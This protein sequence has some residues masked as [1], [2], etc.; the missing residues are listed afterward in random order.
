MTAKDAI[1]PDE[2]HR[3][4]E[5]PE[6]SPEEHPEATRIAALLRERFGIER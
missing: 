1:A 4:A 5:Q 3:P 6:P 2:E